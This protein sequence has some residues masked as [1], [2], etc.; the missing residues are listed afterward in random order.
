MKRQGGGRIINILSTTVYEPIHKLVL[1]GATRM[2]VVAYA[3]SLA[4]EV[5]SDNILVNN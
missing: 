3:K 5:G 1:S 4:D 2:G